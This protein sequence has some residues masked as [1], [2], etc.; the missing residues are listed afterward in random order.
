MEKHRKNIENTGKHKKT[1]TNNKKYHKFL[2]NTTKNQV[3]PW[4]KIE[5]T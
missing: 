4:K 1:C 3:K 5:N 2:P